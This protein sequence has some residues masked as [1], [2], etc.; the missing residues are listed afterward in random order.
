MASYPKCLVCGRGVVA[1][2][3]RPDGRPAHISC[4]NGQQLATETA[5]G[6]LDGQLGGIK[7]HPEV[8]EQRRTL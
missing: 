2:Q 4:Q 6:S 8:K 1:G 5:S 3:T 7:A